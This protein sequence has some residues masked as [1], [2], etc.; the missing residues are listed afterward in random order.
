MTNVLYKI[1]DEYTRLTKS[2]KKIAD[3]ILNRPNYIVKMSV[4]EFAKEIGTSAASIV[5][6]SK[7]MTSGGFQDLKLELSRYLPEDTTNNTLLELVDHESIENISS[8][9]LSRAKDTLYDVSAHLDAHTIGAI[10][11]QFK[12]ARTIFL[13]GYGASYIIATDLFQKFSR[14][15]LNV[16]FITETHQLTSTLATHDQRDCVVFITNHGS[17]SELQAMAKVATDYN[18]SIITISSTA[19][20]PVAEI[21][22]HVLTYGQTDENELRMAATTSLFAQLFTV[23]VLYYRYIALNYQHS[24]DSITQSKIAL[25]NYRKH[26]SNIHFKH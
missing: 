15:G 6:F 24:L 5:R 26:I 25:D 16:R 21:S 10:C 2:E 1:E 18:I 14:I 11:D 3:Y 7:K 22:D 23:D 9:L 8:K 13:F 17:H 12:Q 19:N 20:N 4:Q